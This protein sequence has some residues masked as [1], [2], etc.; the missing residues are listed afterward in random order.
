M[1]EIPDMWRVDIAGYPVTVRGS[2]A[3]SRLEEV[4]HQMS[5]MKLALHRIARS[6]REKGTSGDGHSYCIEVAKEALS[7]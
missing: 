3:K 1:S 2:L 4:N 6:G 7:K 5:R